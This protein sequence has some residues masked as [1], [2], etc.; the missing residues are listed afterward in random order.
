MCVSTSE[1]VFSKTTIY[2]GEAT[3]EDKLVHVLAYQNT[4]AS[5]RSLS[6]T[7]PVRSGRFDWKVV[8]ARQIPKTL[9]AGNAMLLP[10]P[11]S[12][13]V[14][15][16]NVI[17]TSRAP[18][19]LDDI[20]EA[21]PSYSNARGAAKGVT[22]GAA[23]S[24]GV[25]VFKTGIYTVV[26]VNPGASEAD[27]IDALEH[28]VPADMRPTISNELLR[29][30]LHEWY[31]G[32]HLA[33][34]CFNNT[35]AAEATPLVWVYEPLH[36][37][38]LFVPGLDSHTGQLPLVNESVYADHTIAVGSRVHKYHPPMGAN[39]PYSVT[40]RNS[41]LMGSDL[42]NV[43]PR[44]VLG[45]RYNNEKLP[46]GDW[47]FLTSEVRNGIYAPERLPPPGW[48]PPRSSGG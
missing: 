23:N 42:A 15:R 20:A 39:G 31:A 43:A 17:D 6:T 2:A 44:Y 30:Y 21:I 35:R 10:I 37:D 1:A 34:C 16:A 40:F 38:V 29:T 4:A 36:P 45:R 8:Q 7:D 9:A 32:W 46:N 48:N 33:I 47:V 28:Q 24:K 26:L 14:T 18:Q 11:A 25:D 5:L 13:Q 22:I 12:A 41:T 19:F 27:V 3:R